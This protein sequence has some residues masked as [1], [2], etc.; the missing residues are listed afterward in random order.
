MTAELGSE[1]GA[2]VFRGSV[3]GPF[4]IVFAGAYRAVDWHPIAQQFPFPHRR[5]QYFISF[6]M[7]CRAGIAS[8]G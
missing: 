4:Q 1:E 7:T 6:A 5:L 2:P 8:K 3:S